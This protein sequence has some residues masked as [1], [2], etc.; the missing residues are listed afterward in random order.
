VR[1]GKTEDVHGVRFMFDAG[2]LV[3]EHRDAIV[4]QRIRDGARP[5]GVVVIAE[6]GEAPG[7]RRQAGENGGRDV[8]RHPPAAE[9]LHVDEVAA[10]QREVGLALRG[11][12]NDGLQARHVAGMR[13]EME[14]RQV[15]DAQRP[16]PSRPAGHGDDET[17]HAMRLRPAE[18]RERTLAAERVVERRPRQHAQQA[19]LDPGVNLVASHWPNHPGLRFAP[20]GLL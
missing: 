9:R 8:R 5:V 6:H 3:V 20:S 19:C 18:A 17:V 12:G 2:Q 13:A 10:V 4:A 7:R 11:L 1:V 15:G 16:L 14:I